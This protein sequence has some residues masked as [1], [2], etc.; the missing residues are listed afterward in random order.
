M[1]TDS[2][3][4]LPPMDGRVALVTGGT[5]GIGRFIAQAFLDAGAQVAVCARSEPE[6]LPESG[7]RKASFHACDV[8]NAASCKDFVDAVGEMH[9]RIDVLVNNAG[10]SPPA[11]AATV[12]P[13]FSEAIIALNL[14]GPLHLC[15]SVHRWMAEQPDGGSIINIASV[16]GQRAAPRTAAYGAAKAGLLNLTESLA[17]EWGPKIRVNAIVAGLM[18]TEQTELSYG[19]VEAQAELCDALP[20]KRMGRGEDIAAAAL[21]LSSPMAAFVSGAALEVHGGGEPPL[22]LD[23]MKRHSKAD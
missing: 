14:T 1:S 4:Y 3:S 2:Q 17:Q 18:Q 6:T 5:K 23:I 20:L 15:Q 9:G 11:D 19:S 7:G 22:F 13:R 10:G 8:R 12:S 21:Y 16:A